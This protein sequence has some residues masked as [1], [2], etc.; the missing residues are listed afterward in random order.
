MRSPKRVLLLGSGH[1]AKPVVRLLAQHENVHLTIAS[2][3]AEQAKGL[4]EFIEKHGSVRGHRRNTTA[5]IG[6]ATVYGSRAVYHEFVS[7]RDNFNGTLET[8]MRNCDVVVSLLPAN[9]HIPIAQEAIRQGRHMVTASFVNPL[10]SELHESASKAG[11][12]LLNEMGLDPGI[13]HMVSV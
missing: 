6:S 5:T 8:L 2:D 11:V 13:D 1:V 12:V 7:P 4:I 3:S 10:M 9:M